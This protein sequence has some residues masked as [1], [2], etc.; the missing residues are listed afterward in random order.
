MFDISNIATNLVSQIAFVIL[1]VM[2][3]RAVVAYLREDWMQFFSGIIMG[4]L[5]FIVVFFGPQ[6]QELA[7][8]W[9]DALF[10]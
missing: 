3:I 8:T 4:L 5:C 10:G 2:A 6:L 9:G 1:V 7:R